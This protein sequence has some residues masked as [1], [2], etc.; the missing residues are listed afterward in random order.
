MIND[1]KLVSCR[2]IFYKNEIVEYI[3]WNTINYY[4]DEIT[5]L[6]NKELI[7]VKKSDLYN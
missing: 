5:I 3:F 7:I 4:N 1:K 6:L 2:P